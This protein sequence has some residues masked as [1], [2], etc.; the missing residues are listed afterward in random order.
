MTSQSRRGSS[1]RST[2]PRTK[3]ATGASAG[4]A[5]TDESQPTPPKGPPMS[6]KD[7]ELVARVVRASAPLPYETAEL[8]S[9]DQQRALAERFAAELASTNPRFDRG[10]FIAA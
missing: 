7:F 2:L 9:K 3:R 6:K 8:L 1:A 5:R 4:Q 10:R